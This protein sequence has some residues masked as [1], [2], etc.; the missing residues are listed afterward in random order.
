MTPS[1]GLA[2]VFRFSLLRPTP[3]FFTLS[4]LLP[5][6]PRRQ[7]QGSFPK[8]KPLPIT[9]K[10]HPHVAERMERTVGSKARTK[11]YCR[12]SC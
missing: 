10:G 5:S 11:D 3:A 1:S 7:L 8:R 6:I 9:N 4:T 12:K 2:L